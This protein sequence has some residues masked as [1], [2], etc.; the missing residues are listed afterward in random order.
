M[1]WKNKENVVESINKNIWLFLLML[2]WIS[3]MVLLFSKFYHWDRIWWIYV[4]FAFTTDGI[5]SNNWMFISSTIY[6]LF[7]TWMII[8]LFKDKFIKDNKK[9]TN[10][11]Y[12]KAIVWVTLWLYWL[13]YI[14]NPWYTLQTHPRLFMYQDWNNI[15][16]KTIYFYLTEKYGF[17][18]TLY[19][20]FKTLD[21]SIA[22]LEFAMKINEYS[23]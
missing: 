10:K 13:F 9:R 7:W 6:W 21:D 15:T 18:E 19:K 17:D 14:T 20:P 8:Y 3:M 22:G 16:N 4:P 23:L 11:W 2:I 5:F 12:Y 1:V